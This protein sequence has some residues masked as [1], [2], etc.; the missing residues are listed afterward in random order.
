MSKTKLIFG[1]LLGLTL[2]SLVVSVSVGAVPIDPAQTWSILLKQLG[3]ST[4]AMFTPGQESVLLFIR[5]PRIVLSMLVGAALAISGAGMQ[6]LFRNPLADPSL[7]GIS[8]GA[9]LAAAISILLG[10]HLSSGIWGLYGL[11]IV[12]FIGA[13]ITTLIVFRLAKTRGQTDVSTML[14]AG[15]AIN[16]LASALIGF[17]LY[18]ASDEQMRAITFW[19]F[20]SMGSANWTMVLTLSSLLVLPMIM[21]PRLGKQLDIYALG[22]SDAQCLGVDTQRMKNWIIVWV[23][24]AV[25]ASVAFVGMIGFV[26][27]VIPHIVR[28][29][30]GSSHRY[31]LV[32]SVLAGAVMLSF[33]DSL[34]RTI[35]APAEL[36]IGILTALTGTPL[37]ISLLIS[38]KRKRQHV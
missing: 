11:A 4:S 33:A 16:A 38:Q 22:E 8:A 27:L 34:C 5:L 29:L 36:P 24:L 3:I 31:L 25:G 2:L 7:V 32:G 17:I 1:L 26:G 35:V 30:L 15:I 28:M 9:M 37:F 10:W 18:V 19:S 12:T 20:G 13:G 14:L 21:I 23:T 6:G